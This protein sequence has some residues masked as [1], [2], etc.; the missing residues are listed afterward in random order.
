MAEFLFKKMLSDKGL[1]DKF[2]VF[3]SATSHEEEGNPVYPPVRR[4]LEK[5]GIS[6]KGKY[7]T[8]LCRADYS[9][10]DLFVGMDSYN[11][12]NMIRIFGADPEGKITKLLDFTNADSD[13]KDPY[14]S[15]GF[16][17]TFSQIKTGLAALLSY[18]EK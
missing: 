14:Y 2:E 5:E 16:E 9:K 12:R 13:V 6:V 15:G 4:I 7:A 1:S 18:L 17:E 10:Y 3:S 8:P 11:V